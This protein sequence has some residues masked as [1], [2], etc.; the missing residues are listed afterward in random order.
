MACSSLDKALTYD[1]NAVSQSERA[2]IFLVSGFIKTMLAM[3]FGL[4]RDLL[5]KCA[6]RVALAALHTFGVV[7]LLVE[8]LSAMIQTPC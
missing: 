4:M 5:R 7:L 8:S 6:L 1:L 2:R 3:T